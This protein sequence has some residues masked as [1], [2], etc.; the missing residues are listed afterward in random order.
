VTAL[1]SLARDILLA[2]VQGRTIN[3]EESEIT[4]RCA[5]SLAK[6]FLAE[7]GEVQE[8]EHGDEE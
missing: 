5:I 8:K 4:A 1:E 3:L 6:V 7:I 2:S